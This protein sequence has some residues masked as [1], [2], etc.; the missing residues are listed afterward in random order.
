MRLVRAM[1]I[2]L[3]GCLPLCAFAQSARED[4][5]TLRTEHFRVHYTP[6]FEPWARQVA[7]KLESIRTVVDSEVG[8]LPPYVTDVIVADPVA[9]ANG[10][11]WPFLGAPR[12]VLWASPPPPA[13]ALGH[14]SD[15]G[16][17]LAI[18]EWVHVAHLTRPSRR[19]LARLQ[20]ALSP[21]AL[22][23]ISTAPRW[24]S[25]G[26]ATVLEGKLT[27]QGRPYSDYRAAILRTWAQAGRLPT[28]EQLDSDASSWMGMSM[29]YLA[30]SAYLEW[31]V[32]REGDAS[33]RNLWARMTARQS[34]SF[35]EAFEGVYGD[36]PKKLYRRFTAELTH[37]AMLVEGAAAASQRPGDLW[38]D[39]SWTTA[40][41]D[42]SSDGKQLVTIVRGRNKPARLAVFSTEPDS[43]AETERSQRI[44]KMLARDREDVAP[45]RRKPLERKPKAE[46]VLRPGEVVGGA[47]WIG[48]TGDV[49][50]TLFA[51]DADGFL[52][53]DIFRWSPGAPAAARLTAGADLRDV[54][55]SSDGS[56]ALAIR[57]RF[58]LS[59][60]VHVNLATG[61]CRTLAGP[62]L[63][64]QF[65][66]PALHPDATRFA[67]I[68]RRA[69][70]WELV[71]RGIASDATE[72]AI[73]FEGIVAQPA[74]SGDGRTLF[75]TVA[76][77]GFIEISRF[78]YDPTAGTLRERGHVTRGAGASFAPAVSDDALWF[79]ALDPDGL[80]LR[81]MPLTSTEE[82]LPT[83]EIP[84]GT[85]PVVRRAFEGIP[86]PL[87]RKDLADSSPYG[88]GRQ[89][90][91]PLFGGGYSPSGSA[92]EGGARLGDILGRLETLAL[93]S[94][95]S[96]GAVNGGSLSAR[97]RAFPVDLA[98]RVFTYEESPSEQED[99]TLSTSPDLDRVGIEAWLSHDRRWR[100]GALR[101][102]AALYGSDVEIVGRDGFTQLGFAMGARLAHAPML[103]NG[104]LVPL[105]LDVSAQ[106]GDTDEE[107]WTRARGALTIAIV[108]G[109]KGATLL[110]EAGTA[111]NDTP[112]FEHFEIGGVRGSLLPDAATANRVSV[113]AFPTGVLRGRRYDAARLD[114]R[115]GGGL[116]T[117]FVQRVKA[118][119]SAGDDELSLAGLEWSLDVESVPIARIP[120]LELRLGTARVLDDGLLEDETS[121][122]VTMR[123]KP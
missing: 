117:L 66:E 87:A 114:L 60:I 35:D 72:A 78:D 107:S 29:A 13:S 98:A 101:S 67:M 19:P 103:P 64:G 26:Y 122:W 105:T 77:D 12:M 85:Q 93:I 14:Q 55:P 90:L 100:G 42:I 81:R 50:F 3:V 16:E 102:R 76:R 123:W 30:G 106:A 17:L 88:F 36:S 75:A 121:F 33:L 45:V 10:S 82:A 68:R 62:A 48:G 95:G 18:H 21:I 49:L 34:R 28:Y 46:L 109:G 56:F 71:V 41:P 97:T 94:A 38:M 115:A 99:G 24:I 111:G 52:H 6:A 119:V 70:R 110:L 96:N 51:P 11:A 63:D 8:Y 113:P 61:D 15:W 80:D 73:T 58:G 116:P 7:S 39:L 91:S 47:R 54:R 59:E 92:F 23:P 79:L 20:W 57:N 37:R 31:L 108:A 40:E 120:A 69:G 43:N 32:E 53:P 9:Q 4:W 89:E 44:E 1:T 25:E 2:L 74:W 104:T 84:A 86:A 83:P 118:D 22:G 5:Q 65:A 27:G 112:E